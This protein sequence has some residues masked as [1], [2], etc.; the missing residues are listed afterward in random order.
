[1]AYGLLKSTSSLSP[2]RRAKERK[3]EQGW[4]HGEG[5]LLCLILHLLLQGKMG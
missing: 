3:M 2:Q 4:L 1:V 5:F